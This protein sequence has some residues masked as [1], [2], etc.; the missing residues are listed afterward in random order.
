MNL[1]LDE[2]EYLSEPDTEGKYYKLIYFNINN[3]ELKIFKLF[4][5]GKY[6]RTPWIISSLNIN[7]SK[8]ECHIWRK[9]ENDT[10]KKPSKR[11]LSSNNSTRKRPHHDTNSSA[12]NKIVAEI[13][14]INNSHDKSNEIQIEN[15]E[16]EERK[17]ALLERQMKLR[18]EVA[19]VEAIELQNRQLKMNLGL[20][21][22]SNCKTGNYLGFNFIFCFL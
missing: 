9:H 7:M 5:K 2:I 1:F 18:K 11:K 3:F 6:Y 15:I 8:I 10:N 22:A 17:M 16:L 20:L 4:R 13:N 21:W 19:E 14:F 12:N